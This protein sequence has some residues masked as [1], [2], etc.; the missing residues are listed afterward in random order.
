MGSNLTAGATKAESRGQITG[1]F[2]ASLSLA[3]RW[4]GH[5]FLP[6]TDTCQ[7][8]AVTSV[9]SA[10]RQIPASGHYLFNCIL[11]GG[12][13]AHIPCPMQRGDTR[14]RPVASVPPLG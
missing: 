2:F 10:V 13:H 5:A 1:G 11:S 6:T 3:A 14:T 12:G 9:V 4:P 8:D 7:P